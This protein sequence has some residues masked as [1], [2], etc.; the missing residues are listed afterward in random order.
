MG[1]EGRPLFTKPLEVSRHLHRLR[2]YGEERWAQ[3]QRARQAQKKA[4][5]NTA[6]GAKPQRNPAATTDRKRG[7]A[8]GGAKRSAMHYGTDFYAKPTAPDGR[9]HLPFQVVRARSHTPYASD[10]STRAHGNAGRRHTNNGV[11]RGCAKHM[12]TPRA[13]RARW[14]TGECDTAVPEGIRGTRGS[15]RCAPLPQDEPPPH[16]AA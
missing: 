7:P 2:T 16:C 1:L 9:R 8:K 4:R 15:L 3:K 5:R 13:E 10:H 6:Q 12:G 14:H 11:R